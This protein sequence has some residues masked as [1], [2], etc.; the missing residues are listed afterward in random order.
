MGLLH[1]IRDKV[2]PKLECMASQDGGKPDARPY[3]AWP[4]SAAMAATVATVTAAVCG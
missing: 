3:A 2:T 1:L 4:P